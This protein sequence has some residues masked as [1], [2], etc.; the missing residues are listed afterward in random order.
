MQASF[1]FS[2]TYI[3]P[4]HCLAKFSSHFLSYTCAFINTMRG[5]GRVRC[6]SVATSPEVK[7][8]VFVRCS[9]LRQSW[10]PA[11]CLGNSL[12]AVGLQLVRQCSLL[13]LIMWSLS[14]H[15]MWLLVRPLFSSPALLSSAANTVSRLPAFIIEVDIWR[16]VMVLSKCTL[17]ECR[18][19]LWYGCSKVR[20]DTSNKYRD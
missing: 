8:I 9:F 18:L 3:G 6:V 4:I 7:G 1:D 14:S 5:L 17:A 10:V 12:Q 20:S 13:R 16:R 11:A 2:H 15:P 19:P